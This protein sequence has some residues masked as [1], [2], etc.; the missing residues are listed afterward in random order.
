M[1]DSPNDTAVRALIEA[2]GFELAAL[3][4][5]REGLLTS[6]QTQRLRGKR[7]ARGGALL[8]IGVLL[9]GFGGWDL[10]TTNGGHSDAIGAL[11]LGVILIALRWSDFGKSYRAQIAAGKVVWI[12]GPI[13]IGGM[14]GDN[15]VAYWYEI[16]GH[17]FPTTEEGAKAIVEKL[18]YR[19]Y[20]IPDSDLMVNI[21]P[22][23]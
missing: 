22:L 6:T 18:R 15:H 7:R 11:V 17:E 21:E 2:N 10:A 16:A 19:V 14:S 9:I 13:R 12:D 5:N 20:H 3:D 8:V 4:A 23:R 1:T